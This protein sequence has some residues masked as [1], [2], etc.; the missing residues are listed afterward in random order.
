MAT[1]TN[2]NIIQFNTPGSTGWRQPHSYGLWK[3][4]TGT[5][6]SNFLGGD[7][8]TST[9]SAPPSGADVLLRYQKVILQ[10]KDQE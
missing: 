7:Q 10:L 9:V 2:I 8:L 5:G 1:A 6:A 4:A 3:S